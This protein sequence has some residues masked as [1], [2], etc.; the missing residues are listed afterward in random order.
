M[1]PGHLSALVH[2]PNRVVNVVALLEA[3]E[4]GKRLALIDDPVWIVR[5]VEPRETK[6]SFEVWVV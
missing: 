1:A 4:P 3:P 2:Y 6:V 5:T